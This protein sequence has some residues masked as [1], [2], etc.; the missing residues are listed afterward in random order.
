MTNRCRGVHVSQLLRMQTQ[1]PFMQA[2]NFA[3]MTGVQSGLSLA[4]K[5]ARGGVEDVRGAYAAFSFRM[6]QQR[7][8]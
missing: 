6:T 2:R 7:Q 3:V 8:V 4:I 5:Q 1:S